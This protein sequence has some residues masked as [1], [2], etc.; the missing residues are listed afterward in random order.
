MFIYVYFKFL[1]VY[2]VFIV[3]PLDSKLYLCTLNINVKNVKNEKHKRYIGYRKGKKIIIFI[4][5]YKVSYLIKQPRAEYN[6]K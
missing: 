4:K 3:W 2:S 1:F 5:I 6:L